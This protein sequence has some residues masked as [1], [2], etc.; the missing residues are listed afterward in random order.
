MNKTGTS[1]F[2]VVHLRLKNSL[3]ETNRRWTTINDDVLSVQSVSRARSLCPTRMKRNAQTRSGFTLLEL[4]VVIAI[5]AILAALLLPA[6][7][8]AKGKAHRTTCLNNLKQISLGIRM[9]A[10]DSHDTSPRTE[11]PLLWT[12]N[13]PWH[14]YKELMKSY[15]G[16]K[17]T[18]SEQDHLFACPADKFYYPDY[19]AA[20]VSENHHSQPK[21]DYSSYAFNAG[22]YNTNFPGIA[23]LRLSAI[24]DPVK[25]IM[26]AEAP[27][28]W[29]YSW[30]RPSRDGDYINDSHFNNARDMIGFVDGHVSYIKMYLDTRNVGIGH[31]EAW[32]YDPPAGY[33]YKWSGN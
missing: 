33:D 27:A 23:G 16:L 7:N 8:R 9:Y 14:V 12:T 4:L 5:I 29:P 11:S 24:R 15:V 30:H 3:G 32:H 22:N 1:S 20:R 18:P 19:G 2:I 28:L 17:G 21:Y 31:E 25:T 10:D 26:I 13:S 6:V